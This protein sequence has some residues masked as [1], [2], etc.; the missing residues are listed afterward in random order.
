[1]TAGPDSAEGWRNVAVAFVA[2]FVVFGVAYSFGAFFEPMAA[3]FGAG[4]GA[5]SAV[6]SITA[7]CYFLLGSLSGRAVDR[8][9][10]RPVLLAGALAMGVGLALTAQVDRLWTGY[11]AY[12]FGVGVGVACGY[13][14][15]LAVVGGWFTHRRGVALGVAVAGIG[16]GTLVVAPLAAALIGRYGWR[17][18][19]LLFG[20]ASAVLLTGCALLASP[21][22]RAPYGEMT[23]LSRIVRTRAFVSLYSSTLLLSL[24]LFVPFVFLPPFAVEQG[25]S[26]VAGATLVGL[27]GMASIGGRL[28]IGALADRLGS[29]RSYL[30]CFAVMAA[31]YAI[32]LAAPSYGWLVL[33]AVVLGVGY[34]GFI[35]L[36]PA[37]IAEL[38]GVQGLG[39]LVGLVYTSAAVGSLLGPPAAGLLIDATSTYRWAVLASMLAATAAFSALLPLRRR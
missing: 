2:M 29:V 1:V 39:G 21:P 35:A 20:G 14:P 11:L 37:V 24:A 27:I 3:E 12:G 16:A 15:M 26:R 18:T 25:A 6:F 8:V 30:G 33:F 34:G 17:A 23:P 22:P 13:V 4:S 31:S 36:N 32:W 7:C 28:L 38:F 5:T 9:G 10:P 19:Y